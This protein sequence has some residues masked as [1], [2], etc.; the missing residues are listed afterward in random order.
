[1]QLHYCSTDLLLSTFPCNQLSPSILQDCKTKIETKDTTSRYYEQHGKRT[2]G[3]YGLFFPAAFPLS[4]SHHI[5]HLH[6]YHP[7]TIASL[8]HLPPRQDLYLAPDQELPPYSST[9]PPPTTTTID[10][11]LLS[12][13]TPLSL[14]RSPPAQNPC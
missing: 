6:T 12:H 9:I 2:R 3:T 5:S 11:S 10:L 1:M 7:F 4:S 13:R 14:P 8:I